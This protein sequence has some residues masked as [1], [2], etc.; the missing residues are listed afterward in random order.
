MA[1]RRVLVEFAVQRDEEHFSV[2]A[3][4][5]ILKDQSVTKLEFL[6]KLN[7]KRVVREI[8]QNS[9]YQDK[10]LNINKFVQH[11]ESGYSVKEVGG[12]V[13]VTLYPRDD[14]NVV[15]G[16]LPPKP[17]EIIGMTT[18]AL[19]K[20]KPADQ[21]KALMSHVSELLKDYVQDPKNDLRYMDLR[22][23]PL[24]GVDLTDRDLTGANISYSDLS[25]STVGGANF[26][27]V[28]A[29]KTKFK[30]MQSDSQTLFSA[31]KYLACN[32]NDSNL[33]NPNFRAAKIYG[34]HAEG[35]K[36]KNS[37][38]SKAYL[39]WFAFG[40]SHKP[41]ELINPDLGFSTLVENTFD[42]VIIE[43]TILGE[44]NR[45]RASINIPQIS[46]ASMFDRARFAIFLGNK[47]RAATKAERIAHNE[48]QI[49]NH[50]EE[51]GKPLGREKIRKLA[52]KQFTSETSVSRT[53]SVAERLESNNYTRPLL[54]SGSIA[55]ATLGFS[56][57]ETL[58][59]SSISQYLSLDE[60]RFGSQILIGSISSLIIGAGEGYGTDLISNK[61]RDWWVKARQDV[62]DPTKRSA[63]KVAMWYASGTIKGMKPIIRAL[64]ATRKK[65]SR[66]KVGDFL[67]YFFDKG[68]VIV[69]A[70][71]K[72]IAVAL[73]HISSNRGR[74]YNLGETITI[75]RQD[76]EKT[77]DGIP[78]TVTFGRDGTT[79]I[80]WVDGEN[81]SI[82][83]VC[84]KNGDFLQ[85]V[86]LTSNENMSLDELTTKGI[87]I[88]N[89]DQLFQYIESFERQI[90]KESN[91][92][93]FVY[94][95]ENQYVVAG[96]DGSILVHRISDGRL[97]GIQQ[98]VQDSIKRQ[99]KNKTGTLILENPIL[100]STEN[101]L[102]TLNP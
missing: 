96:T 88:K 101:R 9:Q 68:R 98:T 5:R 39:Q 16:G 63:K 46:E 55:L 6:S 81:H 79:T 35:V 49:K 60:V 3:C 75:T 44:F 8:L 51:M 61:L 27:G 41:S 93:N 29:I 36:W 23:M 53:S 50:Q 94:D 77:C 54:W 84:D 19:K 86:D 13:V 2:K 58:I 31:G 48:N 85:A 25:D 38:L 90:L 72:H 66:T 4:K 1:K 89:S 99:I 91:L 73:A 33:V 83:A 42:G 71:K 37:V 40:S 78:S 64:E 59:G 52:E 47:Y 15:S 17:V 43:D 11:K 18:R 57:A 82:A 7:P 102:N 100:T 87:D 32:F 56:A 80:S 67:K 14:Y 10:L 20:G 97:T 95:K 30:G 69:V 45:N 26:T 65:S 62:I 22:G 74:G 92:D 24:S 28:R 34:G 12:K 70:D 76:H 21:R